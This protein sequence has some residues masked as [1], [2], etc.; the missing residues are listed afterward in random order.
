MA[1]GKRL[2]YLRQ[3]AVDAFTDRQGTVYAEMLTVF[4]SLQAR[5]EQLTVL[6]A[7]MAAGEDDPSL[8]DTYGNLQHAFAED[9]GYDYE[10]NIQR[11]LTGLGLGKNTWQMPISHLSGGQKTRLLLARLLLEKPDLLI[12][13]EPTNHLDIETVAWLESTLKEWQRRLP[14]RQP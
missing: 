4:S 7:R 2:G 14:D 1:R 13:D 11:T 5:Q 10:V 9:G 6:E 3:E 12:L 8:L